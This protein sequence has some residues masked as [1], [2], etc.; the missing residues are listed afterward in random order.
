MANPDSHASLNSNVSIGGA[1]G[2]AA[3]DHIHFGAAPYEIPEV[4]PTIFERF[5]TNIV[6][7]H[8]STAGKRTFTNI[9]IKANTNPTFTGNITIDGIVYIEKP[10]R[11]TFAGNLELTGMIVT[12][13]GHD[14]TNNQINFLGITTTTGVED[15]PDTSEFHELRTLTGSFLLAPGFT[16]TFTGNVGIINGTMAAD[17]YTFAGNCGGIIRGSLVNYGTA[18]LTLAGNS[19]LAFDHSGYSGEPA[20]FASVPEPA[21]LSLLVAA[22]GSIFTRRR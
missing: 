19:A 2:W 6:D 15:L 14:T 3:Y 21:A 8:T 4:D 16:T 13:P 7:R 18:T 12:D 5:A 20:G 11:V 10:N 9:R 17:A 1:T 22:I